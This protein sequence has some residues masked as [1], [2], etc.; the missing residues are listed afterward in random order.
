[1][2]QPRFEL[3]GHKLLYHLPRLQQHLAGEDVYPIYIEFSPVGLCNHRCEF[4]AYDYIGYPN[5]KLPTENTCNILR[6]MGR[7]GVKSV[8]FAGEG[9]PTLHPDLD[10]MVRTAKES[11]IDVGMFSNSSVF[12][13]AKAEAILPHLTFLRCSFN[14]GNRETYAAVHQVKPRHFDQVVENLTRAAELR[15][16]HGWGV[17]I[18]MQF[19]LYPRSIGSLIDG[20]RTGREIGADY[21]AI[22]PFVQHP[23]QQKLRWEENY[24]LEEIDALLTEAESYATDT[25]KVVARRDS[26]RKYHHR[27]YDKCRALPF[28]A[29]ILSD[30]KVYTCGPYY[31]NPKFCYG[32]INESSFE[33][34]WQG[35]KRKGIMD[36]VAHEL[37][38]KTQC[39]PNCRPD[40]VNRFL[41]QMATPPAHVNFV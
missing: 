5:R 40:E 32:N 37:N 18:G 7:L 29:F 19:V 17:T 15:R 13:E 30:G 34:I 41:H 25:Y 36:F 26:F 35:S 22:K 27:I 3:D 33:D 9:E 16:K 2:T 39:M 14:G 6:E 38:C 12:T 10:V 21:F 23:D 31:E 20:V 4:C 11:G 28:F 24:T 1:M 8:L